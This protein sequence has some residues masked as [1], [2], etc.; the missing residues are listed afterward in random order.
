ME[1]SIFRYILKHTRRDQILILLLTVASLPF[2]YWTLAVPKKIINDAI[3]G[4][5][6]PDAILGFPIDQITYLV[7]LCSLFLVLVIIN[8]VMKYVL[9]VYR[10][11]VGERMLRRLRF[12]LFAQMLRFPLPHYK[13]VSQG[14]M[15]PILISETEPLGGFVGD[16]YALPAFQGGMLITYLFFIFNQSLWLGLLATALYPFQLWLIPRLQR[17]VNRLSKERVLTVRKLGDRLSDSINGMQEIHAN[18]TSRYEKAVISSWLGTIFTIRYDI[19]KRKFFIKF[20]NNFLAQVTPFFFYLLGGYYVINGQLSLGALV[21]A[22]AAFKELND[23]WKELLTYYQSKED[24]R[25]K[26]EQIVEQFQPPGMLDAHLQ[27]APAAPLD[28]SAGSWQATNLS[29]AEHAGF[30]LLERI[31]FRLPLGQK[32]AIV[33]NASSGKE[34]LARLLARL[35]QPT[36]GKLLL[37]EADMNSLPQSTIGEKVGYVS[38]NAHIFTGTLRANVYYGLYT[39]AREYGEEQR[40]DALQARLSGNSEDDPQ[41]DWTDLQRLGLDSMSELHVRLS[42]VLEQVDLKQ[43]VIQLGLLGKLDEHAPKEK[44]ERIV[45]ARHVLRQR[46]QEKE[47]EGL[48]EVFDEQRYNTNLNVIE[49]L[50]FGVVIGRELDYQVIAGRPGLQQFLR[51]QELF[52]TFLRIGIELTST[53]VDL[54]SDLDENSELFERFSFIRY[55]DLPYYRTLLT[56][57]RDQTNLDSLSGEIVERLLA[58]TFQVSPAR[59]RL[60]LIDKVLQARILY[61]RQL[62]AKR[63][64]DLG[65]DHQPFDPDQYNPGLSVQDN[66]LFGRPVYGQAR[67]QTRV[68]QLIREIIES[69]QLENILLGIGLNYHVGTGGSRLTLSQRQKVA[70]VRVLLK[71]PDILILNQATSGLDPIAETRMMDVLLQEYPQATQIWVLNR[72]E[73]ADRFEQVLVMQQ[74]Q[75]VEQGTFAE[76]SREGTVFSKLSG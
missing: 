48:V 37:A 3:G 1:S 76:L 59:H 49:N 55:E 4:A 14:E 69:E 20:L 62:F 40:W 39:A 31:N 50:M 66:L 61:A 72:A 46:L 32:I 12:D 16:A 8:G 26:Y 64:R 42:S 36:Q 58:L 43:D 21:T 11:V 25:I 17:V 65:L 22:I 23:P 44:I 35:Y 24:I 57:V 56:K 7:L 75:L 18:H 33:G 2:M 30:N 67:A 5:N 38:D 13:K 9:N 68:G 41:Q 60:G 71:N 34:E 29:Y 15:L 63:M 53:M 73:L 6:I 28:M 51:D 70:I 74:G 52:D 54:F 47:Y 19:Y 27:D 45:A 10:G